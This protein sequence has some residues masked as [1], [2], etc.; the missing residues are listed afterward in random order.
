MREWVQVNI[1]EAQPQLSQLAERAWGGETVVIVKDG[2]PDLHL[3]PHV[4]TPQAR[5][6]GRLKGKI[7][8]YADFDKTSRS[9][10][11]FED[12]LRDDCCGTEH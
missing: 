3:R 2:N 4:D 10:D 12:G 9:I 11:G 5:K 7:R 6:P 8:M 1:H